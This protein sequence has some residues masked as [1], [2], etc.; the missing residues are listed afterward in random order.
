MSGLGHSAMAV[1]QDLELSG[2]PDAQQV[3]VSTRRSTLRF[4]VRLK[5]SGELRSAVSVRV[6]GLKAVDS[7]Q[8]LDC[9][10]NAA[11]LSLGNSGKDASGEIA[12]QLDRT[13]PPG[14][15]VATLE[16][17]GAEREV[18]FVIVPDTSLRI[19]PTP[20]VI[21][22][23]SSTPGPVSV[24]IEN[25]GNVPLTIDLAGEF[26]LGREEPL[27][28]DAADSENA[29]AVLTAALNRA[30][31]VLTEVGTLD[32]SMQD[33]SSLV[34][35]P[36]TSGAAVIAASWKPTLDPARRYRAFIPVYGSEVEIVIVTAAKPGKGKPG[37][38]QKKRN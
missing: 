7:G 17:A 10:A 24:M 12:L 25:R 8:S 30:P 22:A 2:W 5:A 28:A 18:S 29:L 21:D 32:V 15:Y 34:L 33:G 13:M 26:P 1:T 3:V 35:A 16:V 4:P 20:L 6:T 27:A 23:S 11:S 36:G 14:N 19:R 38:A 31:R 37:V 9:P